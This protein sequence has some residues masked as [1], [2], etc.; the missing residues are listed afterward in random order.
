MVTANGK[1]YLLSGTQGVPAKTF[2]Y[3]PESNTWI[4]K[5]P[6]SA[7]TIYASGA[8]VG[9]KIYVMG[10]L[11]NNQKTDLHYIYDPIS[12]KVTN[13]AALLTPRGY[14]NSAS[15]NGKIYLIGGQNG[16]GTTE[17]YFDEYNPENDTW[18]RK[19]QTPHNQAWYCGAV[20]LNGKFYRIAG[21]RWNVPTDYF[22]EYNPETDSWTSLDPFPIT[23]HA[24]TAV[25]LENKIYVMGG[26]NSEH[27]I[28]SI[29]TY[30]PST[31]MWILSFVKLPE[32]LAYHKAVALDGYIYIYN[33]DEVT[34]NGRL[35]RYKFGS[36]GVKENSDD[37]YHCEIS[38]N[39]CKNLLKISLVGLNSFIEHF[40][41]YN[42]LG[43]CVFR[44]D[45]VGDNV[46]SIQ[47]DASFLNSGTYFIR[48][49]RG[50]D[51]L[52]EKFIK[53]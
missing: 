40:E 41:I 26:Y 24:P 32:P 25:S 14:H 44:S 45:R 10:G 18:I 50:R 2:E 38:P 42:V 3:N 1:I 20:G 53:E 31:K 37:N 15:V 48:L 13:G 21:G 28:D 23:C 43:V 12:N 46:A 51:V 35:W 47:I 36:V 52:V 22:D 17:W 6:I 5:A 9:G 34:S 33:K 19:T 30:Y 39:P 8:G 7:G 29:Y 16:D 27:K 49:Y 11:Q 4:E